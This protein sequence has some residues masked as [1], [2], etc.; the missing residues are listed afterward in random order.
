MTS[1]LHPND[2][3]LRELVIL[4]VRMLR[5]LTDL[6]HLTVALRDAGINVKVLSP[7]EE[8]ARFLASPGGGDALA[9]QSTQ[10][11]PKEQ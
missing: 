3:V 8:L 5:A 6:S 11:P 1:P 7:G 4:R 10:E 2:A 9:I